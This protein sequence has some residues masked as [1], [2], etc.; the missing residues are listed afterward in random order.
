[1]LASKI[2]GLKKIGGGGGEG[3]PPLLPPDLRL[4]ELYLASSILCSSYISGRYSRGVE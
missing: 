3:G 1:M 4:K 2:W